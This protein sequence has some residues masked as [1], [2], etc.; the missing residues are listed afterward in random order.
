MTSHRACPIQLCTSGDL[1]LTEEQNETTRQRARDPVRQHHLKIKIALP[2]TDCRHP[3]MNPTN[4]HHQ[5]VESSSSRGDDNHHLNANEYVDQDGVSLNRSAWASGCPVWMANDR[6]LSDSTGAGAGARG[7]RRAAAA[8]AL[9]CH[10]NPTLP[11]SAPWHV[12]SNPLIV[13]IQT[14]PEST[15]A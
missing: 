13:I 7:A 9:P 10:S 14:I 1:V 3:T 11:S 2:A 6:I 4:S 12:I 5:R 15:L 8:A